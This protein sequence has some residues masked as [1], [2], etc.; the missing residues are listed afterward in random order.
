MEVVIAKDILKAN[1]TIA[2]ANRVVLDK[3]RVFMLNLLGSPGSGKT[4]LIEAIHRSL[5]D[6]HRIGVIEGD[7]AIQ[8]VWK[9][10]RSRLYRST[11]A[12]DVTWKHRW[13]LVPLRHFRWM[14]LTF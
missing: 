7:L 8:S 14:R 5:G 10:C 12:A 3:A 6:I 13:F 11:P 4:T 2:D 1:D 9:R